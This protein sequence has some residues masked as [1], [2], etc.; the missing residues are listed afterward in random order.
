VKSRINPKYA[1]PRTTDLTVEVV[2]NPGPNAY[3]LRVSK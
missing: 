3:D 1:D 2:E